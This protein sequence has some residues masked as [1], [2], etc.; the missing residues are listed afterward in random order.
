MK[1]ENED[2]Q[3]IFEIVAARYFTTQNWKWVNLRKD[4]NK[5]LKSYEELNEQYASYSYVSRDWYVENMGSRN[6][7]MCNTWDEL[8]NLVAFLDTYGKTFHFLVNTGNRKSFC[9]VSDSRDLN[10]TQ[11]HAIKEIQ[12]LGYNTFVF[13]ATVPDEIQFQLLQVRG[14]N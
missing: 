5:I 2:K 3:L 7:H 6:I 4:L 12:K 11:A 10:E 8:K 14:V 1:L 13:L 9:I